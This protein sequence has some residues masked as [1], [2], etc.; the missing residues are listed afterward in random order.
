MHN[1]LFPTDSSNQTCAT[2]KCEESWSTSLTG[3]Y[4]AVIWRAFAVENHI[5]A[6]QTRTRLN[7]RSGKHPESNPQSLQFSPLMCGWCTHTCIPAR[8]SMCWNVALPAERLSWLQEEMECGKYL[9][10]PINPLPLSSNTHTHT[11]T[12]LCSNIWP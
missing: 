6:I 12:H 5:S 4:L 2:D 1:L 10:L 7:P 9:N 3:N 11:H 8:V